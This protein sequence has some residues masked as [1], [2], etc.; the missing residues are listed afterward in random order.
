M[1]SN[2]IQTAAEQKNKQWKGFLLLI[3]ASFLVAWQT[4]FVTILQQRGTPAV[5]TVAMLFVVSAVLINLIDLALG[6]AGKVYR[7]SAR[8]MKVLLP[9]GISNFLMSVGLFFSVQTL[10]AGMAVVLLYLSPVF[11]AVFFL[12]TKMRP[13]SGWQRV[14]IVLCL[15]GCMLVE[16]V[17]RLDFRSLSIT[18][19]LFGVLSGAS[20]GTYT[21]LNDLFVPREM[22]Q[23]TVIT[24]TLDIGAVL[25]LFMYPG[26]FAQF[27][28]LDVV[29][30]ALFVYLAGVTKIAC[31][32]LMLAGT[33]SIGAA[34]AAVVESMELPFTLLVAL[35][36]LHQV[37]SPMQ[38]L[39]VLLV[40]VSVALMQK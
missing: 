31:L 14:A 26:M 22:D 10:D 39:G 3:I 30:I 5:G 6:K 33:R 27:A 20:Y 1:A 24:I 23:W 12:V 7:E 11:V 17:F 28:A 13:V 4:P 8:H 21:L 36:T 37:M 40:I 15:L 29:D 25:S 34:K 38:L 19:I 32:L 9:L 2:E 16:N 18:G 35:V